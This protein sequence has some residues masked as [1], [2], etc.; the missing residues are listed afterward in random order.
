MVDRGRLRKSGTC[1]LLLVFWALA[2]GIP[3]RAQGSIAVLLPP[4]EASPPRVAPQTEFETRTLADIEALALA[5]NPTVAQAQALVD[6]ERGLWLQVGLYPNPL[7][8]YIRTDPSQSNQSMTSGLFFSQEI[9]TPGKLRLNRLMETEGVRWR[10]EQLEAQK[11]RVLNDVRISFY[12][13]LGAQ[14]VLEEAQILQKLAE[15][16]AKIAQRGFE[17]KE[18]ISR[19]DVVLAEIQLQQIRGAVQ[20]ARLHFQTSWQQ[21]ANMAGQP[22]M[23]R[24]RL[25]GDLEDDLPSLDFDQVLQKVLDESP[26][27]K[28]QQAQ[29]KEAEYAWR[30]ARLEAVPN[31]TVQVVAQHDHVQKFNSVSTLLALPVP[32]FN[33]NQGNVLNAAANMRHQKTELDRLRLTLRDQLALAFNQYQSTRNHADR[34]KREV[35]PRVKEY[36]DQTYKAWKEGGTINFVRVLDARRMFFEQQLAYVNQLTDLHRISV[37]ISG[38]L[39]TGGLN[40]TEIGTALQMRQGMGGIGPRAVLL[41]QLQEQR[42]GQLRTL[43]GAIQGATP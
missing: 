37:E 23:P 36:V 11:A 18:K 33:R 34:L 5:N 22:D 26:L 39:L 9:M 43:P 28:G 29:I 15:E 30:R 32:F 2:A 40:P 41:Q 17:A 16:A 10:I 13:A 12:E 21:L 38:M 8:G 6:E 24:F 35:L 1:A 31:L 7:F 19:P 42:G 4:E 3:V 14:R 25:V 27:I 20:D